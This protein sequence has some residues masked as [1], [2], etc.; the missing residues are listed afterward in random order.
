[1]QSFQT[2]RR[3]SLLCQADLKIASC[4]LVAVV[5]WQKS[6][7]GQIWLDLVRSNIIW[8]DSISFGQI[9]FDLVR[10]DLIRSDLK[11]FARNMNSLAQLQR[12]TMWTSRDLI[13]RIAAKNDNC[14]K[15]YTKTQM[16][17]SHNQ[18]GMLSLQIH[19]MRWSVGKVLVK[20]LCFVFGSRSNILMQ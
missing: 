11:V 4:S 8:S 6:G 17:V 1:M 20:F 18:K 14:M 13:K 3:S 5:W 9:R 15:N 16:N 19:Q 2:V 7:F 10:S 12:G